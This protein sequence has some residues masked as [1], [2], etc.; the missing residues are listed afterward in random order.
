MICEQ[1]YLECLSQASYLLGDEETGTAVV[2][3]P[4]RDVDLYLTEAER[5][6][7]A[8]RH[9]FLTHFHADFV[10]GHLELRERTGAEIH[11]GAAARADYPFTPAADGE[12]FTFGKLRLEINLAKEGTLTLDE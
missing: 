11:L 6:G 12:R 5:R 10:S 9:V 7:L 8:I 1:Y 4:R 2:V 3:D